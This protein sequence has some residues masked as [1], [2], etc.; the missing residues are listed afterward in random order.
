M[1]INEEKNMYLSRKLSLY[2]KQILLYSI[3][4]NSE[5]TTN[6]DKIMTTKTNMLS[7]K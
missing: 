2:V 5:T 6:V 4:K 1:V 7:K 3:H